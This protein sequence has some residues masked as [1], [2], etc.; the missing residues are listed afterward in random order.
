MYFVCALEKN[1]NFVPQKIEEKIDF[2]NGTSIL[3]G[4][5]ILDSGGWRKDSAAYFSEARQIWK[6]GTCIIGSQLFMASTSSNALP[7]QGSEEE[8]NE[9]L[10]VTNVIAAAA[11]ICNVSI[12]R[13]QNVGVVAKVGL[14]TEVFICAE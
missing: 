3:S 8:F 6:N 2:W 13:N 14:C 4:T 5:L 1:S 11:W 10:G 12:P 7:K 9:W